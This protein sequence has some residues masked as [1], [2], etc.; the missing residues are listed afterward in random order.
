MKWS[1]LHSTDGAHDGEE[2]AVEPRGGAERT[3][4]ARHVL[5]SLTR[6]HHC[7]AYRIPVETQVCK[8]LLGQDRSGTQ[9]RI[10]VDRF[11]P[12]A[13]VVLFGNRPIAA[14]RTRKR[15]IFPE[16][17]KCH[18]PTT[19]DANLSQVV[20]PDLRQ[21]CAT[22]SASEHVVERKLNVRGGIVHE[23]GV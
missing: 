7:T 13:D 23:T 10:L 15:H 11:P 21:Q 17:R 4:Y 18:G 1:G 14:A 6:S 9:P 12:F 16:I 20:S 19:I 3:D 5:V 2:H 8:C 22:P